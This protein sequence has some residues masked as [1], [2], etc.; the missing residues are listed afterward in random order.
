[1][2][3]ETGDKI[4]KICFAVF[5]IFTFGAITFTIYRSENKIQQIANISSKQ[6]QYPS[7]DQIKMALTLPKN[8]R[9]VS[10]VPVGAPSSLYY[11]LTTEVIATDYHKTFK[12]YR[13]Q[14]GG[15]GVMIDQPYEFC[16]IREQNEP[17]L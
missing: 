12:V 4:V 5:V 14:I 11:N 7:F 6:T 16:T 2:K 17:T 15:T 1:M 10:F 8:E 9:F 13:C 3:M